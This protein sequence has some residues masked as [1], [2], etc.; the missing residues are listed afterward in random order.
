MTERDWELISVCIC[1]GLTEVSN[2]TPW[3]LGTAVFYMQVL[4]LGETNKVF[5]GLLHNADCK[6]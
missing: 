1:L 3:I 5:S 6:I 4:R 2:K